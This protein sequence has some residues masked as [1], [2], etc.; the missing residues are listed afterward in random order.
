MTGTEQILLVEDNEDDVFL[1][2]RALKGAGISN[3][4]SVAED[5]QSAI[6]YLEGKGNYSD[7]T[8]Y[9]L[10]SLIFLDLKLPYVR[11]LD[12]LAWIKKDPRFVSIVVVILTSSEEPSDLKEAYLLG[13]NSYLVKPPSSAQLLD[14]AVAFKAYWVDKNEFGSW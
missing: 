11:G 2:K 8:L 13:V 6:D 5:G 7:R 3:P 9:P 10:P 14:L 4:L 12:V 1:M